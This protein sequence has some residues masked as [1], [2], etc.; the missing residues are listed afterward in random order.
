MDARVCVVSDDTNVF[1][2]VCYHYH[3]SS[4]TGPLMMEPP[5]HATSGCDTA[6]ASYG[7]DKLKAI[8]TSKKGLGLDSLGVIDAPW[9]DVEKEATHFIVTAY[10]GLGVTMSECR[11]RL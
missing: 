5:V 10:D 4:S 9:D 8:V 2:V 6:A 7:I 11:K 1:A 3:K